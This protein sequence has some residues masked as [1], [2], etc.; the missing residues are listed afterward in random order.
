MEALGAPNIVAAPASVNRSK[1]PAA[2]CKCHA[3]RLSTTPECSGISTP[4]ALRS[5]AQRC[6]A[7][8]Y[9]GFGGPN[10]LDQ[11]RR[12]CATGTEERVRGGRNRVAV[13]MAFGGRVT[14][15]RPPAEATLGWAAESHWDSWAQRAAVG[16]SVC[17]EYSVV[18]TRPCPIPDSGPSPLGGR[19]VFHHVPIFPKYQGPGETGPYPSITQRVQ[20]APFQQPGT[21][22]QP[23]ARRKAVRPPRRVNRAPKI[24]PPSLPPAAERG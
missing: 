19:D 5:Q 18:G 12:G 22:L 21:R 13:E 3:L 23:V 6:P 14:Q 7:R 24:R 1:A 8:G 9:V 20:R 10:Q 4:T 16:I 17:C 15:G 11:P 2:Q